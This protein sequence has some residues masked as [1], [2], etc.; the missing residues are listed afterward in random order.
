MNNLTYQR[1]LQFMLSTIFIAMAAFNVTDLQA[2]NDLSFM[3]KIT[4]R[5]AESDASPVNAVFHGELVEDPCVV[6]TESE[7]QDVE[8]G[9][10]EKTFFYI[11][12]DNPVTA[13]I[14]FNLILKECDL[15]LGTKVKV[16]LIGDDDPED[17]GYLRIKGQAEGVAIGLASTQDGT[18]VAMPI[19]TGMTYFLHDQSDNV[20]TF[21]A[22][23]KGNSKR[24][25]NR[26]IVE[27]DF[28]AIAEFQLEYE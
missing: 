11:H 19:N 18:A 15:S 13:P 28:T 21:Q 10:R 27:G 8:F 17:P 25:E 7:T 2:N 14:A 12:S 1:V 9:Q 23:L 20:L 24:I 6:S 26:T 4:R 3:D 5:T 16:S 22:Y